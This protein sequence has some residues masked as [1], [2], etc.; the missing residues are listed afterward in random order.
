METID[1]EF[2]KTME[3]LGRTLKARREMVAIQLPL[4][5][6]DKRGTPNSFL[7]SSL[8]AAIQSK[9]RY[10]TKNEILYA[11][12]G[13]T[14]EYTGERLNQEDLTL[15]ETLVHLAKEHPL[16]NEC[17]F[18]AHGIL[19]TMDMPTGGRNYKRL[20]EGIVRLT[21]GVI[22]VTHEGREYF[23]TLIDGGKRKKEENYYY[24]RL[25]EELLCLYG[26]TQY[27]E[28]NWGERLELR[29]KPLAQA[30]HVF[31]STH[32]EPYPIK[33][34]TLYKLVGSQ[35]NKLKGFKQQVKIA[36]KALVAIGV[37]QSYQ[38]EGDLVIVKRA[39][40]SLNSS[41]ELWNK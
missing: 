37:L 10:F 2:E 31:Y 11:Q 20:H 17:T 1:K 25:N 8:F 15:W 30:L 13:I 36:L 38:I 29:Q 32:R 34:D 33:L 6:E 39:K 14:V 3:R 7:R 35:N 28:I 23:G 41:V 40:I 22:E 12:K 21:G 24:L 26:E 5:G 16:G 4:W 9:D 27:T 19:K 18:T